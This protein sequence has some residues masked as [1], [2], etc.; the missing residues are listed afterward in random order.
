MSDF[1][2]G[3][4]VTMRTGGSLFRDG[5]PRA[6]EKQDNTNHCPHMD[7]NMIQTNPDFELGRRPLPCWADA[8]EC[9]HAR[10]RQP[11]KLREAE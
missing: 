5:I 4:T 6:A 9:A 2:P 1:D 10:F 3:P 8:L 7:G 11:D